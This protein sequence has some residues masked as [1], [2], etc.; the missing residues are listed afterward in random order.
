MKKKLYTDCLG[1][2]LKE[3]NLI[4]IGSSKSIY[5]IMD[6]WGRYYLHPINDQNKLKSYEKLME[7]MLEN[8]P[9]SL[10]A[11]FSKEKNIYKLH[12]WFEPSEEEKKK[13]KEI[14]EIYR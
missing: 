6:Y 14:L 12:V 4:A 2:Q 5:M 8:E 13:E 10:D 11:I 9:I 1:K 3:G 7:E